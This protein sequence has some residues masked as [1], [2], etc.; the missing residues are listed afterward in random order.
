MKSFFIA[1]IFMIFMVGCADKSA[2]SKFDMTK[3]QE[4]AASSLQSAKIKLKD[5]ING[6]VSV[7]YLDEVYPKKYFKNEYFFVFLYLKNKEEM[8]DPTTIED[9]NLTLMLN[10]KLPIKVKQLPPNNRFSNLVSTN[11]Q[12]NRYYLVAF[13]EQKTKKLSIVL[14]NGSFSCD[15]LI[16]KK[17][18][19]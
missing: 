9:I 7:V 10:G 3:S 2:F 16:Y 11:N 4:L 1:S 15:P 18:R 13:E 19:Q 14:K 17:D 5:D 12:W 6:I 8:Y